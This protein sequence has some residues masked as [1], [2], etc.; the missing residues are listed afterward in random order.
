MKSELVN[1]FIDKG[2]LLS[3]DFLSHLPESFDNKQFLSATTRYF[4]SND[5]PVVLNKD[6]FIVLDKAKEKL[7]LNWLEFEN[8]RAL[9]EKGKNGKIYDTFLDMLHYTIS[10]EKKKQIESIIVEIKKPES[11]DLTESTQDGSAVVI[12]DSYN[13]EPKKRT[14]K[15][16]ITY[17]RL[18][19]ESMK[20]LL[21][22]RHELT[23]LTSIS[24]AITKNSAESVSVIGA[25][26]EKRT[27]K[28]GNIILQLEDITGHIPV[29]FSKKRDSLFGLAKDLVLDEIVGIRGVIRDKALFAQSI[30]WP[31]VPMKEIKKSPDEAYAAVI[32]DVHIGSKHFLAEEFNK[33]TNW[34]NG[35]LGSEGQRDMAKKVKYLFVVGDIIDGC[36]IY[37]GQENDLLIQD[38]QKQYELCAQVFSQIR[39]D[40]K[41]IVCPGQ[42]D[43]LR[44]AEPQ[45]T[46]YKDFARAL[47]DMDNVIMVSNPARVNIHSSKDFPGF[48]VLMYHGSSFHY[49][50]DNVESLRLNN[51]RDN[52]SLVSQFL[53][54]RRHLAPTHGSTLILPDTSRDAMVIEQV[55]DF[56][57]NGEM[58][59]SSV[60]T[61]NN[62][63]IINSSCWEAKTEYQEK[64]GNNPD[65]CKLPLINLKTREVKMLNFGG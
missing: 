23:S 2:Y 21:K 32:S 15:D 58:H 39:S 51:A 4:G 28:N 20:R 8:A 57:I 52:P 43:A 9:L 50:I 38:I 13:A 7:E 17:F 56:F 14:V 54:K 55:P 1:R 34:I 41:I 30:V 25:V 6:L 53:L 59:R 11:P 33:F 5:G 36:G 27:T 31:D 63:T 47:W 42:H 18:R 62:V 16:F 35:K 45:P 22:D 64:T 49:F 48:D 10:T 60:S 24:K 12:L 61:Y 3:P 46:L 44:L 37:P 26:Y 65:P 40:V 19:Y 29:I